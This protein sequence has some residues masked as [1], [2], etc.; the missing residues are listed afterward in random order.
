MLQ[1]NPSLLPNLEDLNLLILEKSHGQL[2]H[3][4]FPILYCIN[5]F[6]LVPQ[7]GTEQSSTTLQEKSQ[8]LMNIIR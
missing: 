4:P 8:A 6:M 1:K 3:Y 5:F 2:G 7:T